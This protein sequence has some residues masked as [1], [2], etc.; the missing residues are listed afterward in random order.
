MILKK[1][2]TP[3]EFD[4]L[5]QAESINCASIYYPICPNYPFNQSEEEAAKHFQSIIELLQLEMQSQGLCSSTILNIISLLTPLTQASFFKEQHEWIGK[6]LVVFSDEI[7]V[8]C[9]LVDKKL[10]PYAHITNNYYVLP[11]FELLNTPKK[12]RTRKRVATSALTIDSLDKIIPLAFE[13]KI[14]TLCLSL[15][16]SVYGVY[17]EI[18]KTVLI[19]NYISYHNMSLFNL[20]AI[21]TYLNGGK[22]SIIEEDAMIHAELR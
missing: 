22:V 5:I 13:K 1:N 6:T 11:L 12:V 14:E 9:Y 2:I 3:A 17:D 20:A 18:N 10:E 19:D 8:N 4:K 15:K 7:H 16:N 21:A